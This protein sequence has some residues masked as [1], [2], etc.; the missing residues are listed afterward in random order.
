MQLQVVYI[1]FD[2]ASWELE[3]INEPGVYPIRPM[4]RPWYLDKKRQKSVLK[5]M[6][7]QLPLTPA[8]A[9]TAHASQGKTLV[10]VLIDLNVDTRVD[11]T[12]GV[13]A[14]SRVRNRYWVLILRPF[15]LWLFNREA[16]EGP[17][18][19]MRQLRKETINWEDFRDARA[20]Q[21]LCAQ[22][23]SLV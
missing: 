21:G 22:C 4:S 18:C 23:E 5:A 7:T 9:M 16:A 12:F 10:A 19:L 8:Y 13:V 6:R 11:A 14:A 15:P 20:P 17:V 2:D 1:K 3:G